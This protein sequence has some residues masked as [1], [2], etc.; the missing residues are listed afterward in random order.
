MKIWIASLAVLLS[1]SIIGLSVDMAYAGSPNI[2][3]TKIVDKP[4]IVSGT[5]VK[6]T[7]DFENNGPSTFLNCALT[8]DTLTL[9]PFPA[10][11]V[12]LSPGETGQVM[13]TLN[14]VLAS[15]TNT[16]T[17]TCNVDGSDPESNSASSSVTVV[18]GS[19]TI[20]KTASK[21]QGQ[22]GSDPLQVTNVNPVFFAYFVENTG[23]VPLTDCTVTDSQTGLGI[24]NDIPS[25][26]AAGAD[27]T[28]FS[29][30]GQ[31]FASNGQ[32]TGTLSC[33]LLTTMGTDVLTPVMDTANVQVVA[34][35][36]SIVKTASKT[37]G[38]VGSDPRRS[39]R[40]RK[41]SSNG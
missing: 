9:P 3:I 1:I 28:V 31:L 40:E 26:L 23:D 2:I 37:Q 4:I 32:N 41:W 17:L 39:P 15:F 12:V 20:D 27:H 38:Q 36:V 13:V 30:N 34:P 19:A 35:S 18:T 16:A 11:K 25:P 6:F 22:I 24:V 8:D 5:D 33:D 29:T 10:D 7:I 21:T 14:N